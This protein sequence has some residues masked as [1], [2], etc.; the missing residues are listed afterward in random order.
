V[1]G[2]DLIVQSFPV[3]VGDLEIIPLVRAEIEAC[4]VAGKAEVFFLGA[5]ADGRVGLRVKVAPILALAGRVRTCDERAAA[6]AALE[7]DPARA[8]ALFVGAL[9]DRRKGFDLLFEAWRQLS[10]ERGWDVDLLVAGEGAEAA[11]WEQRAR[12]AGLSGR[13]RFLRFRDDIPR[14]LAACD[15]VVH[16]ARYEAYGLG[17]HEAI[18]RGLPSIVSAAAGVTE[19]IPASL[20]PLIVPDPLTVE[21]VIGRLRLWRRDTPGW[22]AL[23]EDAGV[24]LRA[25]SWDD[26]AAAIV[27]LLEPA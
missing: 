10:G 18:S 14:V 3:F 20:A 12:S 25:R 27:G 6:R 4:D 7:L 11:A 24:A 26:M 5:G 9:G 1:K 19:R 17:V 23:A 22:K 21:A 15:L 2:A 8:A 16:P 13:M